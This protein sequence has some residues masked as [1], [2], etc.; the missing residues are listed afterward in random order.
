MR[1]HYQINKCYLTTGTRQL[2]EPMLRVRTIRSS[3]NVKRPQ[4]GGPVTWIPSRWIQRQQR[5]HVVALSIT[6]NK[7]VNSTLITSPG[8]AKGNQPASIFSMAVIGYAVYCRLPTDFTLFFHEKAFF[9]T[10]VLARLRCPKQVVVKWMKWVGCQIVN[11][12]P[13]HLT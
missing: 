10:D 5:W 7:G 9:T 2:C 11:S 8:S 1:L 6:L 3:S 13:R 12:I 4:R